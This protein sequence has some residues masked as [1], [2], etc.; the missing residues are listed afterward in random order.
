MQRSPTVRAAV[1][2]LAPLGAAIGLGA[3]SSYKAPS[4]QS[5]GARTTS[6]VADAVSADFFLDVSNENDE[7]IPLRRVDYTVEL[8]GKRI[9]AGSRSAETTL[10]A[11]STQRLRLPA[12]WSADAGG[13]AGAYRVSGSMTYL[14]PG[15]FAQALFDS[16]V[17]VPSAPFAISGEIDQAPNQ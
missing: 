13:H 1:L 16:G 7:G 5:A 12:A 14:I 11:K 4:V 9:F 2:V 8:D 3:C 6:V 17:R 10:P 15:T